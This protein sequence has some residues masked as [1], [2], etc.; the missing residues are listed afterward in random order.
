MAQELCIYFAAWDAN[1]AQVPC[2]SSDFTSPCLVHALHQ[3][4][5]SESPACMPRILWI[6]A[7]IFYRSR[8][9]LSPIFF[10]SGGQ[11]ASSFDILT[12]DPFTYKSFPV[13]HWVFLLCS[14]GSCLFFMFEKIHFFIASSLPHIRCCFVACCFCLP[15]LKLLFLPTG[16]S[17]KVLLFFW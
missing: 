5:L 11:V 17:G 15:V 10:Y 12:L 13:F 6:N 14:L 3:L 16:C 7:S 1:L 2:H 4:F 8:M 9:F